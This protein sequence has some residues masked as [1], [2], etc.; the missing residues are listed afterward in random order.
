M[1]LLFGSMTQG[2]TKGLNK[3]TLWNSKM[4]QPQVLR[5][6]KKEVDLLTMTKYCYFDPWPMIWMVNIQGILFSEVGMYGEGIFHHDLD[7]QHPRYPIFG[8]RNVRRRNFSPWSG[9][10]TKVSI[11]HPSI[12]FSEKEFFAMIWIMVNK[13]IRPPFK[14]LEKG[15]FH[16]CCF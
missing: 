2:Q 7:G 4:A 10:S 12:I 15:Q 13:G 8:S 1:L 16:T 11:H 5:R 6:K 3:I 14:V 9:W